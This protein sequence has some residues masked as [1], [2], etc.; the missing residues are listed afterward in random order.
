MR[1]GKR[2]LVLISLV[3]MLG[4]VTPALGRMA[5]L[6]GKTGGVLNLAIGEDPAAGLSLHEATS[7]GMVWPTAPCFSNLVMFDPMDPVERVESL[8]GELAERWSWQDNYRNLVFFLR[9][10]V[11]WH[12]GRPFTSRDVKFTF[13][14]VR[15]APDAPTKLRISPRKIWFANIESIETPSPDSVIFRLKRPQPS[16]LLMLAS[17]YSP[18]YPAHVPPAEQRVHCVGTGPFKLKEWRRGEFIEYVHNPDYFVPQRPYLDGLKYIVIKDR[19]TRA[20]AIQSGRVDAGIPGDGRKNMVEPI[21]AA[22]PGLRVSV[23]GQ[24]V[25]ANLVFN[26][27][28][29]PL[30]NVNVRRALNLAIDRKAVVTALDQGAGVVGAAM[31][32]RPW[33]VWGLSEKEIASLPGYGPKDAE[34]AKARA[35][36]A[37]AGYGSGNPLRLE[38]LASGGSVDYLNFGSIVVGELKKVGVE[39]TVRQVENTMW[40]QML[41]RRDFQAASNLTGLGLDDPDANFFENYSCTSPRNYSD[42]CD[43]ELTRLIEAQSAEVDQKKRLGLVAE[44]QRLLARDASRPTTSWRLDHFVQWPHVKNLVPHNV[45]HNWARM[46]DVWLDR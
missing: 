39:A 26:V 41:T 23:V 35:L 32:P 31:A 5:S 10:N 7:I 15:E 25:F 2:V 14:V 6:P 38:I 46:Q 42:Y 36:L 12:D 8:V 18:I 27:K 19:G 22:V 4:F 16:L 20:A 1:M 43:A 44:I 37:A 34:R 33:G 45:E 17:G 3:V 40:F 30:D 11:K 21:K 29:P 9:K 24:N 28:R 13:D